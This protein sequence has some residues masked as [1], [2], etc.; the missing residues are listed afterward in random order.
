MLSLETPAA[1]T[2]PAVSNSFW[3]ASTPATDYP[4]LSADT[5]VD[6][7]VIG[8][9]MAGITAAYLLKQAGLTVAV[10]EADRIL[11]GTTAHTTAK[12]T[13]Q[14]GLIYHRLKTSLGQTKARQY[15]DANRAALR[16]IADT[17][18][19]AQIDCDFAWQP[20]Y[21]YTTA[22]KSVRRIADEAEIAADLGFA[23][24]YLT[25]IPLPF[26]VKAALRFD[27]Q[28]R[29]HPRKYL[30]ALAATIP[31]A[32]SHIFEQTRAVPLEAGNPYIVH[33]DRGFRVNAE[34]VIVATH[35]PC[36]DDYGMYY[37]RV[38]QERSYILGVKLR[39]PFPA[40]MYI[41]A[42]E[43]TRS[44]RS[45]PD[46]DGELVLVVGENHKTGYGGDTTRH[47][48][49]LRDFITGVYPVETIPYRWSTQD[50]HT[51]DSVP[52]AGRITAGLRDCYVATGFAKWGMTGSTA[53]ALLIRDL[54]V[55]G[56]SPWEELYRPARFTPAA[57]AKT[58]AV[59][60]LE[61]AAQF[62]TGKLL[63]DTAAADVAPGEGKAVVI[64]GQRV[65]A[66]R[67]EAGR[68]H[69]VDSTCTH[70][71]CEL[72]WNAAEKTWDCPCH[73]SRFT[74]DGK[75]VEGPALR[76]LREETGAVPPRMSKP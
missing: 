72:K 7:A 16:F 49:H 25:E 32:G 58:F 71:G 33:T 64:D 2:I 74:C 51:L 1:A 8:G 61:V 21:V 38:Y 42:E 54:I 69:L 37:A 39:E 23:A 40:G 19:S 60:N 43:P 10:I 26:A 24:H 14:H 12:I 66:Y 29:F 9:G 44:L 65:G 75:I 47:Y 59:Q 5:T 31:G 46:E 55:D 73:G 15:A 3:L 35:Y 70:L 68:L 52:Y 22:A 63:L 76:P 50:C 13:G 53:A 20:A 67:D 28:A 18:E 36:F 4:A 11:Q 45:H 17:V 48:E 57:S 6:V 62:V 30:L 34:K 27:E 56:A 41:T